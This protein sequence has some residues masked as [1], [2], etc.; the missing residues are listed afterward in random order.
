VNRTRSLL[1]PFLGQGKS[2]SAAF[3]LQAA[4]TSSAGWWTWLGPGTL[5]LPPPRAPVRL[6][7]E[8][9]TQRLTATTRTEPLLR[10]AGPDWE[11]HI[12]ARPLTGPT[13]KIL[14]NGRWALARARLDWLQ[15][16]RF[17]GH[18]LFDRTQ[19]RFP[20]R[21]PLLPL[22]RAIAARLLTTT[23]LAHRA[24]PVGPAALP[25]TPVPGAL[26][27]SFAAIALLGIDRTERLLTP[28]QETAPL[29]M[30][31]SWLLSP[32]VCGPILRQA[33]GSH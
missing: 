30:V 26:T 20:A 17:L 24:G 33:H 27:A 9:A 22:P 11:H 16:R 14:W 15:L 25:A 5:S 10:H 18:E 31:R 4:K 7:V 28:L 6:A 21:G 19:Q 13:D 1:P 32:T 8:D 23:R 12:A 29:P 2:R 3:F